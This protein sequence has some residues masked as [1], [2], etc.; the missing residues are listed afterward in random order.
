MDLRITPEQQELRAE[1]HH[2]L[3]ENLP[4]EYGVGLPP[5][6]PDLDE[7]VA[8]GRSWQARLAAGRLN[9]SSPRCREMPL[10]RGQAD[11]PP[12]RSVPLHAR[13]A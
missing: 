2:W 7:S 1:L 13:R 9:L 5:R 6:N 3:V 11:L 4:W 8:F 10:S 12:T